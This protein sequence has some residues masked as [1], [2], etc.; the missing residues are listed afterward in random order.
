MGSSMKY[1]LH[2]FIALLLLGTIIHHNGHAQTKDSLEQN[3]VTP[4]PSSTTDQAIFFD[5]VLTRHDQEYNPD[6]IKWKGAVN[7]LTC[8]ISTVF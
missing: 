8:V 1:K 7:F 2:L 3:V 5:T 4:P 6:I